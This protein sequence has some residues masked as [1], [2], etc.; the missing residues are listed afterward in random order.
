MA[1]LCG[2]V[3]DCKNEKGGFCATQGLNLLE[4]LRFFY[5]QNYLEK[6]AKSASGV[7]FFF[8]RELFVRLAQS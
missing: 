2:Q 1:G 6:I 4:L 3:T 7:P 5:T 8:S